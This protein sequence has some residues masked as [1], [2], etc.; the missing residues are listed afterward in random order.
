MKIIFKAI[1][2]L[3][4][5][6][7]ILIFPLFGQETEKN[8][9]KE[10][11]I[12]LL[13]GNT[14][15][16][17]ALKHI[18]HYGVTFAANPNDSKNIIA[19]SSIFPCEYAHPSLALYVTVNGGESWQRSTIPSNG[20]EQKCENPKL[21]FSNEGVAYFSYLNKNNLTGS[22]AAYPV[23][24]LRSE[25]CGKT[26]SEV[27]NFNDR[28]YFNSH[29]MF[30]DDS[31]GIYS[32]RI[33][34]FGINNSS[35]TKEENNKILS[36]YY[37]DDKGLTVK[38]PIANLTD[39]NY[40]NCET[41]S[42]GTLAVIYQKITSP[43][44]KN[45]LMDSSNYLF[46]ITS[47]D[48][49]NSFSGPMVVSDIY[50]RKLSS[51]S[52]IPS[53]AV[54]KSEGP[55]KDHI[56]V[57]WLDCR[58]GI[59]DVYLCRSSDKGKNWSPPLIVNDNPYP[60]NPLEG[61]D[62]TC[63]AV[64]IN[65]HGVVGVL[66]YDRRDDGINAKSISGYNLTPENIVEHDNRWQ[67]YFTISLDGGMSFLPNIKISKALFSNNAP[68]NWVPISLE[69]ELSFYLPQSIYPGAGNAGS[70]E[71]SPD[72]RFHALWIDS[73][74]GV[75]Q[76]WSDHFNIDAKAFPNGSEENADLDDLSPWIK[77]VV[78]NT[79]F[80]PR[81]KLFKCDVRLCNKSSKHILLSPLKVRLL[82][83]NSEFGNWEI[84]ESDNKKT[85]VGAI[86]DFTSLLYN[87][88]LKPGEISDKKHLI[89]KLK[90]DFPT[91]KFRF[92][93]FLNLRTEVLGKIEE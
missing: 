18:P 81:D 5:S 6:Y 14:Q 35:I 62:H 10:K 21:S 66:W 89:I 38:G 3:I 43:N 49:G 77:F 63:P 11:E 22:R 12:I 68:G 65:K 20:I 82:G 39:I 55:F 25:N 93:Q 34:L 15:V 64:N 76:I 57:S 61:P 4:L 27:L 8:G 79:N 80:S 24:L 16:S 67:I 26:W 48:G 60:S 13:G 32:G 50:Q 31:N 56:Y 46:I 41:L 70:L 40:F 23:R 37:S 72:G 45:D 51:V 54:D 2:F 30:V 73:R 7:S 58:R 29:H 87:G 92:T 74:S 52:T 88:K 53:L 42:D 47:R 17:T 78:T 91:N 28:F 84:I 44:D 86:W 19:C 71:V 83:I 69:K 33:Y 36:I 9:K 90:N 1:N 59:Y 75:S 85:G